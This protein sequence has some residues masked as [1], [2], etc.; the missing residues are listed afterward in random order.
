MLDD[1]AYVFERQTVRPNPEGLHDE[2]LD[3][4]AA[5][6]YEEVE[7]GCFQCAGMCAFK[8]QE[9]PELRRLLEEDIEEIEELP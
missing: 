8:M 2:S 3:I 7:T 1:P 9:D 5:L 6:G 4:E